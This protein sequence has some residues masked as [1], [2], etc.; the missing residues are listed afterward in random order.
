M[1]ASGITALGIFGIGS[2]GSPLPVEFVSVNAILSGADVAVKWT[3]ASEVNNQKFEVERSID[4][5]VFET[6]HTQKGAGNSNNVIDY[7]Y[8]DVQPVFN[9]S[10]ALYYRIKQTDFN[11]EYS[12]SK[13]VPVSKTV[14]RI[15][16]VSVYPNPFTGVFGVE[17][18][19]KADANATIELT[20]AVGKKVWQKNSSLL[21]GKNTI[22]I[23]G[24]NLNAGVYF[25]TI[26][27]DGISQHIR[28]IKE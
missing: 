17:A 13:M 1:N 4:G 21:A 26:S 5:V 25:L 22:D 23:D 28:M 10:G 16:S 6:I 20:D 27:G 15:E 7:N 2:V 14:S 11:G 19:L 18:V 3:T 8:I 12:Y 24:T 9:N